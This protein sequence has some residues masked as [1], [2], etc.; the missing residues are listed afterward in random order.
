MPSD[1]SL[2]SL[3]STDFV[4][5]QDESTEATFTVELTNN[6][7]I[8]IEAVSGTFSKGRKCVTTHNEK[9]YFNDVFINDCQKLKMLNL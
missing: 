2:S 4:L 6:D 8:D 9:Y 1:I 7:V 5:V 3:S